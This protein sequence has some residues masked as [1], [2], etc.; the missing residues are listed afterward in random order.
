MRPANDPGHL[1]TA[2]IRFV[3]DLASVPRIVGSFYPPDGRR[4]TIT[5][6]QVSLCR[7]RF[8]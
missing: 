8:C 3:T 6:M 1:V 2:P 5:K 7:P 4:A